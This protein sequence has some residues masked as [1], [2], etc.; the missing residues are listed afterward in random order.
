MDAEWSK[1]GHRGSKHSSRG[2]KI[3]WSERQQICIG[4][5]K[6]GHRGWKYVHPG[7]KSD[8]QGIKIYCD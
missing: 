8:E 1:H 6:Y 5:S 4:T 2:I 3:L 7:S